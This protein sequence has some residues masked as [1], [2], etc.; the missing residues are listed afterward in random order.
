MKCY[1]LTEEQL[2]KLEE[3]KLCEDADEAGAWQDTME[4]VRRQ[5]LTVTSFAEL[6]QKQKIDRPKK[7]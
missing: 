7:D 5:Q 6:R 1:W 3:N 4:S 2:N